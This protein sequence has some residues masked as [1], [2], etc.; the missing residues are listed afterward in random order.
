MSATGR[1]RIHRYPVVPI[2]LLDS[3]AHLFERA[4]HSRI[5]LEDQ[6]RIPAPEALR[7]NDPERLGVE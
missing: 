6:R 4:P 2:G 3:T 1:R 7:A 5:V